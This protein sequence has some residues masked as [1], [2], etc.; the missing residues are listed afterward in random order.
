MSF[1]RSRHYRA[2]QSVKKRK[3]L[4]KSEAS[5]AAMSNSQK[6]PHSPN[7]YVNRMGSKSNATSFIR[8]KSSEIRKQFPKSPGKCVQVLK[9]I[10]DQMYRSPQKRHIMRKMWPL[11]QMELA[12]LLLK[13]GKHRA[14]KDVHKLNQTVQDIKAKY[15]SLRKASRC[16]PYSWT[17]F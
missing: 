15:N 14:R 8:R 7:R 12:L 3:L 2:R 5:I 16:T 10:W 6:S 13:V 11:D 17:Q 1:I 4:E 9:H